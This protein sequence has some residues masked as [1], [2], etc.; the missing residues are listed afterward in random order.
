[1]ISRVR[2]I[3]F[4]A[5]AYLHLVE[6]FSRSRRRGSFEL[7]QILQS[8][9]PASTEL[10]STRCSLRDEIEKQMHLRGEQ[11]MSSF[12]SQCTY[13]QIPSTHP[14]EYVPSHRD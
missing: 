5:F 1:M 12:K 4:Y 3:D 2:L 7:E 11:T 13:A 10:P 6:S 14:I 9:L 8:Q